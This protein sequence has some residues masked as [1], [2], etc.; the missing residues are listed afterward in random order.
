MA[1]INKVEL[2]LAN[3]L[4]EL[5]KRADDNPSIQKA[6]L[7][8]CAQITHVIETTWAEAKKAELNNDEERAY[9]IYMRLFACFTALKQA[10]DVA[11]NQSSVQ[12]YQKGALIWLE[13]A[14]QLSASLKARYDAK[15]EAKLEEERKKQAVIEEENSLE[16]SIGPKLLYKYLNERKKN[17]LLID[18]RSKV[19]YDQSHMK[20]SACIHIPADLMNGKGWTSWG[21][22]SALTDSNAATKFKQRANFDYIILFDDDTYEN[23]LKSG[24]CLMG[25]KQAIFSFDQDVKLKHEPLILDGGYEDWMTYYPGESTAPLIS[26]KNI[27]ELRSFEVSYPDDVY[28]PEEVPSDAATAA[29]PEAA[30]IPPAI[31]PQ[32]DRTRKPIN[33]QKPESTVIEQ[34]ELSTKPIEEEQPTPT[35]TPTPPVVVTKEQPEIPD[36][37]MKPVPPPSEPSSSISE[38]LPI[39]PIIPDIALRPSSVTPI[40]PNT[41]ITP[42]IPKPPKPID[43]NENKNV[44][45]RENIPPKDTSK[46]PMPTR[47]TLPIY[48]PFNRTVPINNTNE[49]YRKKFDAVTGRK[50]ILDTKNNRY[51]T[52]IPENETNKTSNQIIPTINRDT[53]PLLTEQTRQQIAYDYRAIADNLQINRRTGLKNLGNSCYMN[54]IIQSLSFNFILTNYFL[55]GDFIKDINTKNKFGSGGL[56]VKEWFKLIY[57]LWCQQYSY[58][59]PQ[60]FKYVVGTLQNAYLGTQQQ[61]AHEFLVFLLD[62]LHE[63]LNQA[64]RPRVEEL[65]SENYK[66]DRQ[67]AEASKQAFLSHNRSIIIDLFYGLFKST[68]ICLSCSY[69]SIRFD[70]FAIISVPIPPVRQCSLDDC[71]DL[72][73]EFEHLTGEERYECS[74]CKRLSAKKRRL[75][76]WELPKIFIVHFK[77]FRLQQTHYIKNETLI[78]YPISNVDFSRWS[79]TPSPSKYSL[80]SVV[81]HFGSMNSGHYTSYCNDSKQWYYCD[82]HS[83]RSADVREL[84]HNVHA[85][86]LFYSSIPPQQLRLPL[87]S[88]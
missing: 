78:R 28:I 68:T 36:R 4:E 47:E 74:N 77:R 83:I 76:I 7:S 71:L 35:P 48:R 22:E 26:K 41:N 45:N 3:N 15:N 20:T 62:S 46:I 51:V 58:I 63:D 34:Q 72:F 33:N 87:I 81:N 27:G 79:Q 24:H 64:T 25:L 59:A 56:V 53:K 82:D 12:Y 55:K 16:K 23:N 9:I 88:N 32:I 37:S 29:Q 67:L 44:S 54:S 66:N 61:D 42:E 70:A 57:L 50:I 39:T 5:N 86:L 73:R 8:S 85:Y 6:K 18:M 10:K 11:H 75:D 2:Y 69:N 30:I 65:K 84:A 21:I 80:V 49:Q 52:D 60:P 14:D 19:D 43:T 1:T 40:I 38:E 13:K 31:V 17:I